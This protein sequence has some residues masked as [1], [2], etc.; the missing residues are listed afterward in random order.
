[1]LDRHMLVLIQIKQKYAHA[2]GRA[3]VGRFS[4]FEMWFLSN[5]HLE[6]SSRLAA[7]FS[8]WGSGLRLCYSLCS[9]EKTNFQISMEH[10]VTTSMSCSE[11]SSHMELRLQICPQLIDISISCFQGVLGTV[12]GEP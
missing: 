5:L 9:K 11:L 8:V 1:M 7:R 10:C 3:L 4:L 12:S 2:G 6:N